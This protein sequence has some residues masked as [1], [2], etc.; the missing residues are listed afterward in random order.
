MSPERTLTLRQRQLAATR[1]A[2]VDAAFRMMREEPTTPF[3]HETVAERAG[4]SARTVY[5][6]FPTRADLTLALW[7]RLRAESGTRWPRTEAG[8]LPA[9]R[10]LYDQFEANAELTRA[11][12]PSAANPG[13]PAHGSAE[14]R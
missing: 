7:E 11:S 13:Y 12:I 14:G 3:S 8:I 10:T 4:I 5:R 6:H 9:L 1:Q 2:I